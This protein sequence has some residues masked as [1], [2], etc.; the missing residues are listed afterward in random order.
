MSLQVAC[1]QIRS[2]RL[3]Y[4]TERGPHREEDK[5]VIHAQ[6]NRI[7]VPWALPFPDFFVLAAGWVRQIIEIVCICV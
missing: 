1:V 3:A 7:V 2:I 5:L 4:I 6:K